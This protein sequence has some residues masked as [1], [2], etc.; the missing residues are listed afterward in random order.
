M[1]HSS[2]NLEVGPEATLF[3]SESVPR[4]AC[5]K[6]RQVTRH[7]SQAQRWVHRRVRLF[8]A[9]FQWACVVEWSCFRIRAAM[10]STD[11]VWKG[12]GIKSRW[13]SEGASFPFDKVLMGNKSRTRPAKLPRRLGTLRS[14]SRRCTPKPPTVSPP[15]WRELTSSSHLDHE[16]SSMQAFSE[17]E[18]WGALDVEAGVRLSAAWPALAPTAVPSSSFDRSATAVSSL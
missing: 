15:S 5:M 8:D 17:E 11:Q 18:P 12:R 10:S 2:C 6:L 4:P 16:A 13:K 7:Q 3:S 14:R 9:V 1:R